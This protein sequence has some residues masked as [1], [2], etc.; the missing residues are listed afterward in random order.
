MTQPE[1][2]TILRG[3]GW[4]RASL[5]VRLGY[6][7]RGATQRWPEV[8]EAIATYLQATLAAQNA[9]YKPTRDWT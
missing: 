2:T 3:I 7:D 1:L 4:S 8:P 9:V 5:A 6:S